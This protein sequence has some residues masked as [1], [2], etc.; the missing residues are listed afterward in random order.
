[1]FLF[2]DHDQSHEFMLPLTGKTNIRASSADVKFSSAK[3]GLTTVTVL[4]GI[5]GL[6]TVFESDKQLVLF[7]DPVTAASFWAPPLA[8]TSGDLK[9]FWQFGTN[10]T[11][12]IGGPYL[13]RNATVA[14]SGHLALRGDLNA[15]VPLTVI[16]PK[17]I[18]SI[19]WNGE[20]VPVDAAINSGHRSSA[21]RTGHLNLKV[22][23]NEVKVPALTNW[24]FAD[25]LPEI[26]S[27]FS[28]ASW[29]VADHTTT[30][31][32]TKPLFGDGRVLY[33]MFNSASMFWF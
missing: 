2:G 3:R 9:S 17:T 1:M 15:S 13:V 25:S 28:D 12:L 27:S 30:N 11:L 20:D 4:P 33:G 16:G 5:T 19:S 6:V 22:K 7:S 23:S 32:T 21:I 8:S 18:N 26:Q 31:I 14:K 10:S 29:I 24:K